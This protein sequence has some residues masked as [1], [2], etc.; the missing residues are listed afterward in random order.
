MQED[1]QVY[2]HCNPVDGEIWFV[3]EKSITLMVTTLFLSIVIR[4]LYCTKNEVFP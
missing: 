2:E 4:M 3:H 1:Y